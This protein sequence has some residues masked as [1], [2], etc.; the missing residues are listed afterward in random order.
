MADPSLINPISKSGGLGDQPSLRKSQSLSVH[1]RPKSEFGRAPCGTSSA[2]DDSG[3]RKSW[4]QMV[5]SRATQQQ[6]QEGG[7]QVQPLM[8]QQQRLLGRKLSAAGYFKGTICEL[9]PE[10]EV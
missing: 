1:S 3:I 6:C 7:G 9:T 4:S 5:D 10:S 2:R 8:Q